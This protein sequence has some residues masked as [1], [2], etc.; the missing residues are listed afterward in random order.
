MVIF[1]ENAMSITITDGLDV[2]AALGLLLKPEGILVKDEIYLK[3]LSE[4][5]QHA[6]QLHF[7]TLLS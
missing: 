4:V 1:S 6:L 3:K 5:F 2:I 7:I